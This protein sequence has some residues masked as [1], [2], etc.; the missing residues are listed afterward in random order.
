MV[1]DAEFLAFVDELNAEPPAAGSEKEL[2]TDGPLF[3]NTFVGEP[4]EIDG[5][6][7][8]LVDAEPK[9]KEPDK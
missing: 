6:L 1:D 2:P 7:I 9:P 4:L 3:P 5:V 8:D